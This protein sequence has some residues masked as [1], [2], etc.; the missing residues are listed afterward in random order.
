MTKK[1]IALFRINKEKHHYLTIKAFSASIHGLGG[2]CNLGWTS[3]PNM[4]VYLFI[5]RKME[6]IY[7]KYGYKTDLF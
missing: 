4:V 6:R 7:A 1:A 5:L 3:K 2:W